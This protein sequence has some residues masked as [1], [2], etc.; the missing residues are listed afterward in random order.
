M[1]S[2]DREGGQNP[3]DEYQDRYREEAEF[4]DREAA[5]FA[6]GRDNLKFSNDLTYEEYFGHYHTYRVV[7]DFVGS[8][9]GKRILDFACGSGYM[10]IYF[11]RSG[12]EAYGFDISPKSIEVANRMAA[13]NGV[14]E[15][16]EFKVTSAEK[17]DYPDG[18]FDVV[19]GNAALH[20]T[21]LDRSPAEIARVLK[22][23]GKAAF[24]DDL[25]Y[26]PVMWLYRKVTSDKH[27]RYETPML[28]S[29][30]ARFLPY[31]SD[32]RFECHNFF[33]LFE[34]NSS[35]SAVTRALDRGL[36]KSLPFMKAFCRNLV[37]KATK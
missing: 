7:R 31:F 25:R 21:D 18:F 35:L 28:R 8:L 32:V 5:E 6:G 13:D 37:I 11:A 15:R 2:R 17:M 36:L 34:K 14:G 16:C 30:I 26:H 27:T 33:N 29:D 4:F 24:I 19:F 3:L 1:S 23:G 10:S 22:P 20:H 9:K 12:A